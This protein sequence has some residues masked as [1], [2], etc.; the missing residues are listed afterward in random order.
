MIW[1]QIVEDLEI[2]HKEKFLEIL[3]RLPANPLIYLL[4]VQDNIGVEANDYYKILMQKYKE[5]KKGKF[6]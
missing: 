1:K 2:P 5:E 3:N 4:R 6:I